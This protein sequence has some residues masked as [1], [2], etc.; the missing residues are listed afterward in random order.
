VIGIPRK[1]G[2]CKVPPHGLLFMSDNRADRYD[3]E[4]H[5]PLVDCRYATAAY[6]EDRPIAGLPRRAIGCALCGK[7]GCSHPELLGKIYSRE[8]WEALPDFVGKINKKAI[9][10]K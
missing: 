1:V 2:V 9:H 3:P 6:G 7:L 8:E 4:R 10:H 5:G